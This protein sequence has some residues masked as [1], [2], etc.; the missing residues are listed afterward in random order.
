MLVR[1]AETL[2]FRVKTETLLLPFVADTHHGTEDYPRW[3]R[4][5]H[6]HKAGSEI[7][8]QLVAKLHVGILLLAQPGEDLQTQNKRG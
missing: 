5:V 4:A 8:G 2:G 3:L 1:S 6:L 7:V